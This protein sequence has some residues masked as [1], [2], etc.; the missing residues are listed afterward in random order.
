MI[1]SFSNNYSQRLELENAHHGY[2]G[3][4]E[5]Q[6][7]LE[8]ELV[9]KE[10]ALRESQIRSMHEMGEMKRGQ[11]L[12]VDEFSVQKLRGSHETTRSSVEFLWIFSHVSSQPARISSPRSMPSCDKRL[13]PET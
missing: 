7:R 13:L 3:S 12:Q 6:V 10:N 5:E 9:M 8:E 4:R 11:A 2:V 1:V